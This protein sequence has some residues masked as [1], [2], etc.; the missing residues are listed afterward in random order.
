MNAKN[1][2][3]SAFDELSFAESSCHEPSSFVQQTT[4]GF[5]IVSPFSKKQPMPPNFCKWN[6]LATTAWLGNLNINCVWYL[7]I[8]LILRLVKYFRPKS[9]ISS[10]HLH[11]YTTSSQ[12]FISPQKCT[13]DSCL[14]KFSEI[15]YFKC[16][17]FYGKG[18]SFMGQK[19]PFQILHPTLESLRDV[20]ATF[21]LL[22]PL[23]E[24]LQI[25]LY[26]C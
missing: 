24:I 11:Y 18:S 5:A 4:Q 7:Y 25:K 19:M 10:F 15:V 21:W 23:G 20:L 1:V 8:Q 3:Q 26:I 17:I 6:S 13:S 22:K 12:T 14:I 2:A 16:N 9:L